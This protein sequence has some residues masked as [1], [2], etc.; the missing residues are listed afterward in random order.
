MVYTRSSLSSKDVRVIV[1]SYN[2]GVVGGMC[3]TI[4]TCW[5]GG[6]T[7]RYT[8]TYIIKSLFAGNIRYMQIEIY[9]YKNNEKKILS[10]CIVEYG[11]RMKK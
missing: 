5:L 1:A 8:H 11:G 2:G 9:I 10:N 7:S 4:G 6:L 3:M